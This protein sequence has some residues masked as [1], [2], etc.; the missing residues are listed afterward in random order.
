M[1]TKKVKLFYDLSLAQ[2]KEKLNEYTRELARYQ[3]SL[4]TSELMTSI[5]GIAGLK[6]KIRILARRK[7]ILSHSSLEQKGA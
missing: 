5:G 1:T 3:V 4:E 6:R 7:A 2:I